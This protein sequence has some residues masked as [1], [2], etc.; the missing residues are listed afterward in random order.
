MEWNTETQDATYKVVVN[1]E[2]Q[3]ALWP[4]DLAIPAGWRDTGKKGA[5]TE[6][7]EYVKEVWSDL[8]PLSLRKA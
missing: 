5:K 6:C 4:E 2:E 7:L 3:H 8:T 1:G